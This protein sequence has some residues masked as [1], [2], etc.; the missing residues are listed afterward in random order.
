MI[1]HGPGIPHAEQ[2]AIFQKFVRG[3]AAL[4]GNVRGTGVG[5]AMVRQIAVAHGGAVTLDSEPGIGSTFTIAL[6]L[7]EG[8]HQGNAS[9]VESSENAR[10]GAS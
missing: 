6:P 8:A 9:A 2:R 3:R 4:A 5:L 1:D 10:A 7:A